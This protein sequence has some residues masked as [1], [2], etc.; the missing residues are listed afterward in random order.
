MSDLLEQYLFAR[1]LVD[2]KLDPNK[3]IL[4]NDELLGKIANAWNNKDFQDAMLAVIRVRLDAIREELLFK[5]IPQEVLVLRQSLI[6]VASIIP[7][8]EKYAEEHKRRTAPPPPPDI[9]TE[10]TAPPDT[11]P[12]LGDSV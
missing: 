6:D 1:G 4:E 12:A 11:E 3:A 2:P 7:D 9:E 10:G 5:A 8:F